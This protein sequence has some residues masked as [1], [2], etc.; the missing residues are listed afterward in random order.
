MKM[1]MKERSE[2]IQALIDEK[3]WT[4]INNHFDDD[5]SDEGDSVN[6][7]KP[8][9]RIATIDNYQGEESWV[10]ILDMTRCNRNGDIGFMKEFNRMNVALSRAKAGLIIIGSMDTFSQS[11]FGTEWTKWFK[12][13]KD[14][15]F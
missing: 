3:D 6:N 7:T 10:I 9:V 5:L 11:Q 13:V 12:M 1:I 2:K 14:D 15:Q 4:D 8:T